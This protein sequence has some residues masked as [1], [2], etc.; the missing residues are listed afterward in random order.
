MA[1]EPSESIAKAVVPGAFTSAALAVGVV[2]IVG[3]GVVP[4]P[5]LDLAH[6]AALF[7]R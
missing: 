6:D 2:A 1:S 3:L 4:G 7:L 5:L